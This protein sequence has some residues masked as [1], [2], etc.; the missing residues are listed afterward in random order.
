MIQVTQLM[1]N[2][3]EDPEPTGEITYI[4][5][6]LRISGDPPGRT[7]TCFGGVGL[8]ACCCH[9]LTTHKKLIDGWIKFN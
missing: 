5:S 2:P 9:H 3:G 6:G 8:Q 1:G 4:S 7:W